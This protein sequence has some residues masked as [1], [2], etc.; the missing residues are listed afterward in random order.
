[1][2][3]SKI[4]VSVVYLK[5]QHGGGRWVCERGEMT[6]EYS[7]AVHL[8]CPGVCN[9]L[10]IRRPVVL[11]SNDGHQRGPCGSSLW[12]QSLPTAELYKTDHGEAPI[13]SVRA[14]EVW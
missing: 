10:Q 11:S 8:T 2:C 1:M 9:T 12:I 7:T 4:V 13:G 3:S 14:S 5:L 6:V